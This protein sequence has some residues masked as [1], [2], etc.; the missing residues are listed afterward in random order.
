GAV[1][2]LV[3]LETLERDL[4]YKL[5]AANAFLDQKTCQ[6]IRKGEVS[7]D[8]LEEEDREEYESSLQ[9]LKD[10]PLYTVFPRDLTDGYHTIAAMVA[11]LRAKYGDSREIIVY[12]DYLQLLV[13][14]KYNEYHELSQYTRDLKLMAMEMGL[15]IV[16]LSQ[17][18]RD[19]ADGGMPQVHHLRGSGTIEQDADVAIML[20]RKHHY[21]RS[22]E[23]RVGKECRPRW[24][25][26]E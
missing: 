22:E 16:Y 13:N 26:K 10:A 20:N 7:L 19:G 24:S 4:I 2:L 11:S 18:S 25:T 14:D 23:R 5:I 17:L 8:S 1:V 15:A 9:F 6:K 21:D 3:S 12:I